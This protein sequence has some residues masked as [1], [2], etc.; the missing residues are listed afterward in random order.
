VYSTY[1][2]GSSNEVGLGIAVDG[3][4]N[5]YVT[6]YTQSIDYDVTAGAFQT[7]YGGGINDVF[8]TKFCFSQNMSISLTSVPG[9]DNQNVCINSSI[10]NITYTTTGASGANVIGLPPGVSGV[11]AGNA[12]FISGNPTVSG[13]YVYTVNLTGGCGNV[14]TTGTII[15][16]ENT[17]NL[18]S[19]TGTNNQTVCI[20]SSI[21]NITYTTTGATGANVIGLPAGVSGV[22]AGNALFISGTPTV[23]GTY[24]YTVNLTGGCGNVSTTG[25]IS[26]SSCAGIE[27]LTNSTSWQI[28]PNPTLGIFTIISEKGGIFEIMDLTGRV[29]N[30]FT[31]ETQREKVYTNL[32]TG[33]YFIREKASGATQKLIVE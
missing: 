8:V 4:G 31:I 32:P 27:E 17:I 25:T 29:L 24:V 1:I 21:S 6:G 3:S 20:N 19:G 7:T 12:V 9:T 10:T 14:S 22:Y 28:F 30:V 5:A 15:V 11:Y 13:T 18:T 26:V 16:N 23:S 33:I 2:G